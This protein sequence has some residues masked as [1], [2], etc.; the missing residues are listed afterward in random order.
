MKQGFLL[1]VLVSFSLLL[2]C[3]AKS[4]NPVSNFPILIQADGKEINVSA[5]TGET[6]QELLSGN[7]II[8]NNLDRVEPPSYSVLN[9]TTTI[10]VI[11]ITEKFETVETSIPFGRQT[12]QN[13][14]L[15]QGQTLLIQAGENGSLQTTYRI[16]FEDGKETSRTVFSQTISKSEIPE[17]TMI[18]IQAISNPVSIAGKLAYIIAGNA[19]IMEGTTGNRRSLVTTG[20]LDGYV[21]SLSPDGQWLL[22]SRRSQTVEQK[23]NTLWLLKTSGN[24]NEPIN[25][26]ISNVIHSAQ[27][28]PNRG[29]MVSYTTVEPRSSA[30]GWQ[31]NN[32]LWIV[33]LNPDG[34]PAKKDQIIDSNS[35]GLFGWWGIQ[36][37]WSA[38]GKMLAY[39][40]PDQIGVVDFSSKKL[41]SVISILPYNTHGD[42]AWLPSLT[43][44]ADN[45]TIFFVNHVPS[46]DGSDPES[47]PVFHL[48]AFLVSSQK[49][50]KL[51]DN[52]GMFATPSAENQIKLL[53]T[54]ILYFKAIF[55]DQSASSRYHLASMGQDGSN[56]KIIFPSEGME[57]MEPK[58]ISW[59][60]IVS[61]QN[62][63]EAALL[64]K[65]NI[66]FLN[67]TSG[68]FE[69][70][71]GD[72]LISVMDW[73]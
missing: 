61:G 32:D 48:Y 11:R 19:W 49:S 21:F 55:P 18:G 16:V 69:Q 64:Y 67:I 22:F 4:E 62:S 27:W 56:Q 40:L 25:L 42:W 12:V 17:I 37:T 71:T 44:S 47:S 53:H 23:I 30:P 57:G 33:T 26:S 66:W 14:S 65:G 63:S 50:M 2:G 29:L 73:K 60:P 5:R 68:S 38:D 10:K 9:E 36:Y 45:S 7:G 13:E 20:D 24:T 59:S 58:A 51:V 31:A 46:D 39:S 70:I 8:L 41:Q 72:G 54:S 1:A 28:I 43:W 15:Q 52:V 6:V 35:G 3:T 34:T